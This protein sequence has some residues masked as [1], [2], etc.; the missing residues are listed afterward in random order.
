MMFLTKK[1]KEEQYFNEILK[2][3]I[4]IGIQRKTISLKEF[5]HRLWSRSSIWPIDYWEYTNYNRL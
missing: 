5:F 3:K 4:D 1:L 2:G